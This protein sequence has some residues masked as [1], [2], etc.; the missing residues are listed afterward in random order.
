[1]SEAP[2]TI[3]LLTSDAVQFAQKYEHPALELPCVLDDVSQYHHDDKVTALEAERD[4]ALAREAALKDNTQ[5]CRELQLEV[6]SLKAQLDSQ[7]S[8]VEGLKATLARIDQI[9][10]QADAAPLCMGEI[11][12]LIAMSRKAPEGER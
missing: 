8:R 12:Q 4:Q 5:H 6:N 9:A 1:M 7:K 11:R 2:K 3:H 10:D